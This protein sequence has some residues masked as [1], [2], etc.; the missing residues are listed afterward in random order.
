MEGQGGAQMRQGQVRRMPG[1][2]TQA[3]LH[4]PPGFATQNPFPPPG[5]HNIMDP[6]GPWRTNNPGTG[7][8]TYTAT[9]RI[10]PQDLPGARQNP[11]QNNQPLNNFHA[12]M[13]TML[14]SMQVQVGPDTPP[15]IRDAAAS[16]E[17]SPF[18]LLLAQLL[19]GNH[20][21]ANAV[22][23][24]AVYT[25]EAFDRII[26][27]MMD[28]N[29]ASHAPGPASAAAIAALPKKQVDK[30]MLGS[31]GKAEC[32]V[33]MDP[34]EIGDSVTVLPCKHW[35]HGEC[36]GAWLKEHDTCPHCRQGIMPRDAGPNANAPRSPEQP[37]RHAQNSFNPIF[38]NH[39]NPN[40]WNNTPSPPAIPEMRPMPGAFT[41]PGMQQ[42]YVPGGYP[43]YPE[44]RQFVQPQQ[45]QQTAGSFAPVRPQRAPLQTRFG[46]FSGP[47][48]QER[49]A[50]DQRPNGHGAPS[51]PLSARQAT[52]PEGSRR[53]SRSSGHSTPASAGAGEGSSGVTGW[54]RNLRGGNRSDS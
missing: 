40:Y 43:Q 7:R 50:R 9:A 15:H 17:A 2:H 14:Q 32:S 36:V 18:G 24:D 23:G 25:Q 16:G 26:G 37:P 45:H 49:S 4:T 22:H 20:D 53:S 31:D 41:Q 52:R 42:P 13:A 38:P 27:Q 21:P 54:F 30:S 35:F 33:C 47:S 8:T 1:P 28:Q 12:V 29:N 11:N 5:H 19:G 48:I 44:P 3:F 10:W 51:T 34:V 6:Q 39:P 46:S